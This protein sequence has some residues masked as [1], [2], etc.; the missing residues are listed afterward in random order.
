MSHM[1]GRGE[2]GFSLVELLVVIAILGVVGAYTLTGLVQGM[3]TTDRVEAR[4]Q[5][6]TD[7]QRASERVSRDLRRGVWT[8][9]SDL[10]AT[11]APDG[12]TF[13][14]LD[15]SD[16]SVIVFTDGD[17]RRHRYTMSGN[18]LSL[19]VAVWDETATAWAVLSTTPVV[20]D[21]ANSATGIDLF[22]YLDASGEDLL[23]DGLEGSDR[24]SVRKFRL[25]LVGDVRGQDAV[26]LTTIVT[27][28]NGGLQCPVA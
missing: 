19:E 4:V 13:L 15:A 17:R 20:G 1:T 27:A 5:T 23:A 14:D 22:E 16:V 26:E 11:D 18:T 2:D 9:T 8:D 24:R 21:L 25:N 3:R 12:C 7:L 10:S 28:R 6:F